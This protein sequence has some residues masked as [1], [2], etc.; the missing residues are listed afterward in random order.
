MLVSMKDILVRAS[1]ENYAVAAP[2]VGTELDARAAIEVAEEIK[3][4]LIL[5]VGYKANPDIVFYGQMLRQLAIQANVPVAI[6]LD[7]GGSY[8]QCVNALQGGFTSV[9]IDR[10]AESF[11]K[12]VADTS[13]VVK[14][15]HAAGASVEA[16]LGHVGQAS[17]AEEDTKSHLTEPEVAKDF[18]EKTGV[19]MLAVAIGT[20][21]GAYPKGFVPKLDHERLAAIKEAVGQDFPLVLHGSSGTPE[22]ELVKVCSHGINKVNIA[23][24]LCNAITAALNERHLEGQAA[25]EVWADITTAFKDK[26]RHM[27]VDVYGS[28]NKAW[29]PENKGVTAGGVS[30]MEEK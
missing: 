28:A 3:S 22:D 17:N 20:A 16:E 4:P 26:L 2:N 30:S 7:H 9:M 25:Y 27:M 5:D 8:E 14:L 11:E 15:A 23:N 12:N 13:E 19:D 29:V 21:H 10:S 1:K 6:N 18:I 24:D